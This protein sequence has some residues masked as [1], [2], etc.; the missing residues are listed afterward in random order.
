MFKFVLRVAAAAILLVGHSSARANPLLASLRSCVKIA[1]DTARLA[2]FDQ[3]IA[4]IPVA[5]SPGKESALVNL[6]PE[7][8][9]GLSEQQV[10]RLETKGAAQPQNINALQAHIVSTTA[11]SRGRDV[12]VLDNGQ[13]WQQTEAQLDFSARPGDVVTIKKGAI[14]SFWLFNGPRQATRVKRL[15]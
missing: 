13:T 5:D 8:K 14:G 4:R 12:Y 6:S 10:Q 7:D 1:N 11:G 3:E 15:R 2:C 9:L